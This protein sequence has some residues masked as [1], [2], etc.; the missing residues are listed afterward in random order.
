[1]AD[2]QIEHIDHTGDAGLRVTAR[3]L[4]LLLTTCAEQMVR[5]CCPESV[6]EPKLSR[7]LRVEGHRTELQ[8]LPLPCHK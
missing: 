2:V 8:L 6:I 4:P 5:I 1:M 3:S 7:P